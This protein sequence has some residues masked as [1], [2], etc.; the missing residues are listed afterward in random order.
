MMAHLVIMK[1]AKYITSITVDS[2]FFV[3]AALISTAQAG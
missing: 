2:V 3:W 1:K